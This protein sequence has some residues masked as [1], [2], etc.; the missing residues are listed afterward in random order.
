MSTSKMFI[1]GLHSSGSGFKGRFFKSLFPALHSPDFIGP[2]EDRMIQLETLILKSDDWVLIGSSLGGLMAAVI[3]GRFPERVKKLILLAP[4][5]R[6][7]EYDGGYLRD[8]SCPVVIYHGKNDDVVSLPE[9]R[10]VANRIFDDLSFHETDDDHLLHQTV[11]SIDW[12]SL[13]NG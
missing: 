7:T 10:E 9:A 4:A 6:Y 12:T 3:A 8:V 11:N 2:I 1:H 5:L 13:V